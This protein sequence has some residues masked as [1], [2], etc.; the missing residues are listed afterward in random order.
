[1]KKHSDL[2]YLYHM[3]EAA[4]AIDN[5]ISQTDEDTFLQKRQIHDAVIRQFQVLGEAAKLLSMELR[6]RYSY[7]P[8]KDITG[9]RDILVHQYMGIDLH[10]V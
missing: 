7:I 8:W 10:A 5:D 2:A 9:M 4:R 3:L 6:N 1:M